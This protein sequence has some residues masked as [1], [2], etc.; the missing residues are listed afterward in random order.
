MTVTTQGRRQTNYVNT[1]HR[2]SVAPKNQAEGSPV[3][4]S[5]KAG[6]V[7]GFGILLLLL[8]SL[9]PFSFL[10]LLV[11]PGFLV[12]WLT[13][14]LLAGVFAG[15]TIQNSQQGGKAGWM[16][17]FW[18]GIFGGIVAMVMA[19]FGIFMM[20]FGQGIVNQLSPD[21]LAQLLNYGITP[22]IVALSG[23]VFGALIVFG[24]IGSLISG[25]FSSIG[26]MLYPKLSNY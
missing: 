26:G 21:Q 8:I 14:G 20:N 5:L 11:I 24:L 18:A 17:G 22:E 7:G 1:P 25:L 3:A 12:V 10:A 15:D 4:A 2:Q 16:A 9:V 13:T 23:R 6:L 19:A